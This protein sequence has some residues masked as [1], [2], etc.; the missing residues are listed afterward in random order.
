MSI[1]IKIGNDVLTFKE[2]LLNDVLEYQVNTAKKNKE[3]LLLKEKLE[4]LKKAEDKDSESN[5]LK[6]SILEE[7]SKILATETSKIIYTF[8]ASNLV[9]VKSKDYTIDDIKN[10]KVPL[11]YLTKIMEGL[12]E[13]NKEKS[14]A[15]KGK[16]LE[17]K[18]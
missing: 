3:R 11:D 4:E 9:N 8:L 12:A 10:L 18:S 5:K 13:S 16:S 7:D 2:S 15:K 17:K 14:L 1:E 6:I